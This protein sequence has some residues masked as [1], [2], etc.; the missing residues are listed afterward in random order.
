[1]SSLFDK[2]CKNT[3]SA[4][5]LR[6]GFLC[7]LP[8]DLVV[9]GAHEQ[10]LIRLPGWK[11]VLKVPARLSSLRRQ[12]C[13]YRRWTC[14]LVLSFALPSIARARSWARKLGEDDYL[15]SPSECCTD[16]K[17]TTL[18]CVGHD[19]DGAHR[20]NRN[21][22]GERYV[23]SPSSNAKEYASTSRDLRRL[24]CA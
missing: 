24:R 22:S 17:P 12:K 15:A 6:C 7:D 20:F 1:M 9:A 8:N 16:L 5:N 23:A 3:Q 19:R 21:I 13:L 2:H 18:A 14:S 4:E 11:I 10:Q